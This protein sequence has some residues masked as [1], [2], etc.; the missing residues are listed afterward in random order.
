MK[1]SNA[2]KGAQ[3]LKRDD[4]PAVLNSVCNYIRGVTYK[5]EQASL[6][7]GKET[8]PVL[9][10]NNIGEELN[11]K[12]LMYVDHGCISQEQLLQNGD[13]VIA[14]SSGSKSVVGKAAQFKASWKG[15]FGAFCGV[16]RPN[17]LVDKSYFG[18]FFRT[19]A[20]R[21]AVR[22]LSSG[23]NINNLKPRLLRQIDFPL[24]SLHL[25]KKIVE[26]LDE[27][28]PRVRGARERIE[29]AK[30]LL[31]RFRQ[32]VLADACSGKLTED[33]RK[34]NAQVE[35]ADALLKRMSTERKAKY[36]DECRKAKQAKQ[37]KP[38]QIFGE[39][40]PKIDTELLVPIPKS[41]AMTKL[42]FLAH[43]TKLAGFEYT[44]YFK[45]TRE[46][47]VP[48]IKAQNVQMGRF[49]NENIE[50]IPKRTSDILERSQLHG[51][52]VLMVF[53]GAGTG[54]VCLAPTEGTWHLA[55][56]VAKIDVDEVYAPY[57]CFYLQS[58]VGLGSALSFIKATAQPS[59]SMQ[60]IREVCVNL[61]PLEEQKEIVSRIKSYFEIADR[62]ER[63]LEEIELQIEQASSSVLNTFF[64]K[65]A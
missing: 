49:V 30:L 62:V 10:A 36:E 15:S 45:P 43:V 8:I 51:R 26:E 25:Q 18:H 22:E 29:K 60:T 35:T 31:R 4:P 3:L 54:N 58:P 61:P 5:K 40:I 20:Y 6:L 63:R 7:E 59:L 21:T 11:F 47:E 55:P 57:I 44:K 50:Y 48:I 37:R 17:E 32:A 38:R 41:W 14:M 24:V 16:L 27:M 12:D 34:R 19:H 2:S 28:L 46:G 64:E 53:I 13:V 23:T 42:G 1:S 9:R 52:E 65:P 56:N 33:W 39:Q